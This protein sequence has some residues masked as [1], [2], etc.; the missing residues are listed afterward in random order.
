MIVID[1]SHVVTVF[2][3]LAE[4]LIAKR[5]IGLFRIRCDTEIHPQ[6]TSAIKATPY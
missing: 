4:T 6:K 3:V 5:R 2:F 1:A